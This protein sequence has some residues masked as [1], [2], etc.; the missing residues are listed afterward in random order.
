MS[1]EVIDSIL[2]SDDI[3]VP[4]GGLNSYWLFNE[5][6]KMKYSYENGACYAS[7]TRAGRDDAAFIVGAT[8]NY[9]QDLSDGQKREYVSF[10]VNDMSLSH[11]VLS[12]DVDWCLDKQAILVDG[13]EAP[14]QAVV[15]LLVMHRVTYEYQRI[16]STWGFLKNFMN[17]TAALYLAHYWSYQDKTDEF[18]WT[19]PPGG[20]IAFYEAGN[21]RGELENFLAGK[22]KGNYKPFS[23]KQNYRGIDGMFKC[24]DD[25]SL[26]SLP[27]LRH[28]PYR[29]KVI[30]NP[31]VRP[32]VEKSAAETDKS[33][34]RIR[35]WT[36]FNNLDEVVGWK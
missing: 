9:R 30:R 35:A 23:Q 26:K 14:A 31:F 1:K 32:V 16:A 19:P 21:G 11:L 29:R 33:M 28:D 2:A 10:I 13:R 36:K 25:V 24:E 5:E 15:G 3:T 34:G 12:K 8:E 20:H 22:Y 17:P 4:D 6:G 27:H 7:L 18:L